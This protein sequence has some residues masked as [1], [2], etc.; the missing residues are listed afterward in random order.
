MNS[1]HDEGHFLTL[2]DGGCWDGE[3]YLEETRKQLDDWGVKYNDDRIQT[4]I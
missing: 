3:D 1:L 2:L 4:I